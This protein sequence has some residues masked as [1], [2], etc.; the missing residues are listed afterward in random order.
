M[1]KEEERAHHKGRARGSRA[2]A[3]GGGGGAK[4]VVGPAERSEG[5]GGRTGP[6]AAGPGALA[7]PVTG[8]GRW[9]PGWVEK[10]PSPLRREGGST[11]ERKAL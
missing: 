9:K 8:G 1:E 5:E 10:I 6:V 4:G 3:S 11:L 7:G 2:L